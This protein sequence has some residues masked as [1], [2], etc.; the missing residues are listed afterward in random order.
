[1]NRMLVPAILAL[2]CS[3]GG[4]SS[5][6]SQDPYDLT[7]G[8]FILHSPPD[9]QLSCEFQQDDPCHPD[10]WETT[11]ENQVNSCE[12]SD[13]CPVLFY[14]L[15]NFY[16]PKAFAGVEY[17]IE[18]DPAQFAPLSGPVCAPTG[19]L[20]IE[21]PETGSWPQSGS[22]IAIALT[23]EPYWSGEMTTTGLVLGYHYSYMDPTTVTLIPS[24]LTHFIGWC[25]PDNRLCSPDCVGVMGI[26]TPG[27]PC[28]S[29]APDVPFACCFGADC[30]M[31]ARAEC[32]AQG[33]EFHSGIS[34]EANPCA[35]VDSET[36]S[37][38]EVKAMYR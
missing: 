35:T 11:C 15:S 21:Y 13:W 28:C 38:G 24:P 31:L 2:A 7:G 1:M 34:C 18:Y 20:T 37:W 8:V 3:S 27:V 32:E 4:F 26:D 16:E 23:G 22:A 14:I 29:T 9:F 33:G 30:R 19:F 10:N 5:A 17:G 25:S 36:A 6:W 12:S